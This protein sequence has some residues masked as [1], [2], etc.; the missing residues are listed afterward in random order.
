MVC[1]MVKKGL[2]GATLGAGALF[3]IFGT[4]APSYVKTAFQKVRQNAKEI[5]SPQFEIDRAR[6]EIADLKPAFDQNKE[7][8]ARDEVEAE[9]LE[10]E[11][12]TVQANL[13]QEKTVIQA[14]HAKLKTGEF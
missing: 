9:H 3:L 6:G 5:A 12:A 2:L 14:M 11:V 13:N 1:S 7:T 8:L 4:S 10:R